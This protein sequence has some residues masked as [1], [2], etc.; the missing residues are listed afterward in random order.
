MLKTN[1]ND[2]VKISVVDE[3]AAKFWK[4]RIEVVINSLYFHYARDGKLCL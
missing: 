4:R 1:V 3:V 2:L